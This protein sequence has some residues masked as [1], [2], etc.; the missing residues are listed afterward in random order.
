M[1]QLTILH[2]PRCSK[3]RQTLEIIHQKGVKPE[4]IKYLET[5]PSASEIKQLLKLLNLKAD[6]IMRIGEDDYKQQIKN[7][8]L[9]ESEKID[10][11]VKFPKIIE[12]PIVFND[13]KAIIGRPPE[14][15]LK[16]L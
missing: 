14:N 9:S 15:V 3:S 7:K 5:P 16:L 6:D 8:Q 11:L 2:N 12:R 4:V 1:S 10:L 13:K